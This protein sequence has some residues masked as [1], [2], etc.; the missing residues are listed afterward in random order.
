MPIVLRED[1]SSP[2]TWQQLDGNFVDLNARTQLAWQ[3]DGLEP[4]VREGLGNP[5]ELKQFYDGIYAYAYAPNA[6]NE[7]YA[8]WDVPFQWAPG[9][10]LYLAFHWSPGASAATGTVRWCIEYTG[11][12]VNETFFPPIT[13]A[14]NSPHAMSEPYMNH[15]EVSTPFPGA[16][17]G[18]NQRFLLRIYRDGAHPDDTF[19]DDAFLIGVDFYYQTNRFGTQSFTPPYT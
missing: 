11:A 7:S 8:N 16:L 5:A 3:M 4:T 19:P 18:P 10:D 9:T 14:Y 13:E 17:V 1:Q 15:Q 6:L 12:K 2:L